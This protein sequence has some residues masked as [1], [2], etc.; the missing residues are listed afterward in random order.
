MAHISGSASIEIDA[1]PAE[2]W[3]VVQDVSSAPRWHQS[4]TEFNVNVKAVG[5]GLRAPPPLCTHVPTREAAIH[6]CSM[7][8]NP[9]PALAAGRLSAAVVRDALCM[10]LR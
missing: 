5:S 6:G 1:P 2:V 7:H 4:S 10:V 3:S 9:C 8:E